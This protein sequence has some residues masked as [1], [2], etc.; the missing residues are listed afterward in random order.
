MA[1]AYRTRVGRPIAARLTKNN[2]CYTMYDMVTLLPEDWE[3]ET[4]ETVDFLLWVVAGLIP[5]IVL[6]ITDIMVSGQ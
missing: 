4:E 3:E 6:L 2:I 1:F 5:V